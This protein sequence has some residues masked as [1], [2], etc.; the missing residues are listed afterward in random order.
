MLI[1][2]AV[3]IRFFRALIGMQ[4]EFFIKHLVEKKVLG[5]IL[6][7][8][9]TA[10]SRDNLLS[11]ATLE[12]FEYIRKE[13]V[14]DLIKHLV[15]NHRE[16]LISLSHLSTFRDIVMR[17]DETQG[18]TYDLDFFLEPEDVVGRKPQT[19]R[20][21]EEMLDVDSAEEE[22]WNTSDPEDEDEQVGPTADKAP[23]T[24]GSS[25]PSRPLVDYPSDEEA[26]E[27]ADPNTEQF[28]DSE[29]TGNGESSLPQ[30]AP[31]ERLAEKRRREE[32]D[33][34]ELDK[35]MQNKRRN[36]SSS[37]SNASVSS[38]MSRRR[39]SFSAGSGNST[40]KKMTIT[41]SQA[42]KTG[43]G[44]PRSDEEP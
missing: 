28:K 24:N 15:E 41:F 1:I 36:S 10:V 12:L 17:Y 8:A 37:V 38:S 39:K 34:D 4:E 33:E 6:E 31:P 18:Y 44:T 23:S 22:Y 43:G 16:L 19:K 2:D 20:M 3:A 21:M 11:S 40:Q 7:V 35:L 30:V 26:D 9:G 14:K 29:S 32:D 42:L 13:N 5:P 25:T 27:N